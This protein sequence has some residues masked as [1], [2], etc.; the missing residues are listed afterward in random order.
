VEQLGKVDRSPALEESMD[1]MGGTLHEDTALKIDE[2][3]FEGSRV[4]DSKAFV[5][6]W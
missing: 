5:D 1:V 2:E 3:N 6:R 4:G